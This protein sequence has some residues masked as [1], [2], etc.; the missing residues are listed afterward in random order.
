[1]AAPPGQFIAF[2]AFNV[3]K[4]TISGYESII[5]DNDGLASLQFSRFQLQLAEESAHISDFGT[6]NGIRKLP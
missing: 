1:M 3:L 4:E 5:M 6:Q 2:Q